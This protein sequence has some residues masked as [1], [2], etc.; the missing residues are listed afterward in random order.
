MKKVIKE[1]C[2]CR[3]MVLNSEKSCANCFIFITFVVV[4]GKN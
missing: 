4:L 1:A 3:W 2:F